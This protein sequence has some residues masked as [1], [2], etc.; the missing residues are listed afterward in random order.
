MPT[1][2]D[3]NNI[4]LETDPEKQKSLENIKDP[5]IIAL[6]RRLS[7]GQDEFTMSAY[8]LDAAYEYALAMRISNKN[9]HF[10][11]VKSA[12]IQGVET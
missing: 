11:L 6:M 12:D 9:I 7:D 1:K 3:E 10:K 5:L 4:I 2:I 8:E